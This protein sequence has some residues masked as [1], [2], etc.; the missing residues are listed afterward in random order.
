MPQGSIEQ[1]SGSISRFLPVL[2][3]GVVLI[4]T[5]AAVATPK[6]G[7]KAPAVLVGKW[8]KSAPAALPQ[9]AGAE[10]HV[11]L[12]EF[13][14]TW[15]GPCLRSIPHLAELH[16]KHEKDGLIILG[17]SNEEP[18]VVT[19]FYTNKLPKRKLEMPYFVGVDDDGKTSDKWMDEIDGIPHAFLVDRAG[20]IVWSGN[21]LAEQS[22]L[23]QII[24]LALAGKF[25]LE[26]ARKRADA[27]KRYN[28]LMQDLQAAYQ[29]R[30]QEAVFKTIDE[31]IKVK[32][33]DVQP[34]LIKR[35]LLREFDLEEKIAD[36]TR[37][38]EAAMQDSVQGLKD[39]VNAEMEK[40][41]AERSAGVLL[42]CAS[43]AVALTQKR[44]AEALSVLAQVQ[45]QLGMIVQAIATQEQAVALAAGP[46]RDEFEKLLAYFKEAHALSSKQPS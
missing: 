4:T 6:V 1:S 18:D 36:V 9:S 19:D 46:Q 27:K 30:D 42:R 5:S 25:T 41:L 20:T 22:E 38:M 43:R 35:E 17:I 7:D 15:C 3:A 10:K 21:P 34:Y 45:C 31:M 29:S 16:R 12:V 24:E 8:M 33:Q 11:Y 39:L 26:A 14:A 28:E 37:A 44:D 40:P 32:P 2:L 23:D 13:W